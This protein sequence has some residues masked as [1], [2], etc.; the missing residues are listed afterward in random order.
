MRSPPPAS[1]LF[2]YTTL[3][4]SGRNPALLAHPLRQRRTREPQPCGSVRDRQTQRLNA[5][6]RREAPVP[7]SLHHHG[8]IPSVAIDIVYVQCCAPIRVSAL[9]AQKCRTLRYSRCPFKQTPC[10]PS[11]S[12]PLTSNH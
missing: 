2:P 1:T 8:S 10:Y 9:S 7:W 5:L 4:P 3:V 6:P 12:K 11:A